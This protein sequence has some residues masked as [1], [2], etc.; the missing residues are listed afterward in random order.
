MRKQITRFESSRLQVAARGRWCV[1]A[2][3]VIALMA[4]TPAHAQPNPSEPDVQG[5]V[6][7]EDRSVGNSADLIVTLHAEHAATSGEA[8]AVSLDIHAKRDNDALFVEWGLPDGGALDGPARDTETVIVAGA[9]TASQR[10][11]T[12]ATPGVYR[13]VASAGDAS[14][15]MTRAVAVLFFHVDTGGRSRVTQRDEVARAEL[16]AAPNT[17]I[18]VDAPQAA[19]HD[20]VRRAASDPCFTVSGRVTRL[21]RPQTISGTGFGPDMTVPVRFAEVEIRESDLVFD[22]SYGAVITDADGRYSKVFCDDDG[23]FD[24]T[25]EIYVRLHASL[26]RNGHEVVN[27]SEHNDVLGIDLTAVTSGYEFDSGERSSEGGALTVNFQ[28]ESNRSQSAVFNIADAIYEGWQFWSASG[29]AQLNSTVD[30]LWEVGEGQTGSNYRGDFSTGRDIVIADSA[31]D[32]D[33]WDDSVIL[34]ELGHMLDDYFSCDDSPGG[35]HSMDRIAD[36][37]GDLYDLE[38]VWSEGYPNYFQS[39]VRQARRDPFASSYIDNGATGAT[40]RSLESYDT[41]TGPKSIR[42]ELAIAAMLWDLNDGSADYPGGADDDKI[43]LGHRAIQRVYTDPAFAANGDVFDDDCTVPVF[44]KVWKD[45]GLQA[46]AAAADAARRNL[47]TAAPFASSLAFAARTDGETA[48]TTTEA[49]L[50]D[51][52]GQPQFKWWKRHSVVI[53]TSTSMA[54]AKL[55]AAKAVVVEQVNDLTRNPAGTEMSV[56]RYDNTSNRVQPVVEGRFF[57]EQILPAVNALGPNGAPDP[58]CPSAGLEALGQAAR[59]QH[60]GQAWLITDGDDSLSINVESLRQ[61]L[62]EQRMRASVVL[63]A[64]CGTAATRQASLSGTEQEFLGLAADGSRPGGVVPYLLTALGSGGQFLFVRQD[65]LADAVKILR[66]GLNNSAGAGRWSDYVSDSYTL[67][68][69]QLTA[70]EYRWIDT[71]TAAGGT[72][73][74][75]AANGQINFD[76]SDGSR[77]TIFE[78]GYVRTTYPPA[79]SVFVDYNILRSNLPWF[80][81]TGGETGL[82]VPCENADCFYATRRTVGDWTAI[83]IAGIGGYGNVNLRSTGVTREF[84]YLINNVT[85][86]G[87]YQ[88]RSLIA[89]DSGA[90]VIGVGGN[91]HTNI[92]FSDRDVNGARDGMGY[93]NYNAPPQPTKSYTVAVDSL[94]SAVGFLQTGYSGTFERMIVRYPDGSEVSCSDTANVLCVSLNNGLVQYVQVDTN[95]RGGVYTAIVDAGSSGNGTFS[96]S[97]LAASAISAESADARIRPMT[98]ARLTVRLGSVA[99]GNALTGWLQA[100]NGARMG[101]GMTLHDDGEHGD[102]T[103]GDG[104][105]GSDP[106]APTT[107]GVGYLW[108]NGKIGNIAFTRSDPV[109]YTFQPVRV[110]SPNVLQTSGGSTYLGFQIHNQDAINRCFVLSVAL[111]SGWALANL[112]S[113]AIPGVTPLCLA[114]NNS[115]TFNVR[116]IT[117]AAFDTG[118]SGAAGDV[119]LTVTELEAGRIRAVSTTQIA[120]ARPV[121]YVVINNPVEDGY[122]PLGDSRPITLTAFFR[123]EQGALPDAGIAFFWS[124]SGGTLSAQPGNGSYPTTGQMQIG[125][126]PPTAAGVYTVAIQ[127]RLSGAT[128]EYT[129]TTIHVRAPIAADITLDLSPERLGTVQTSTARATVRDP[130][131]VAVANAEVRL[132]LDSDGDA[133]NLNGAEV[134]TGTTNSAGQFS[135]TFTKA[136][137][138]GLSAAIRAELLAR[139]GADYVIVD[140]DQRTVN[141]AARSLYLPVTSR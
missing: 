35:E 52:P 93:K 57:P 139:N 137:T 55:D 138:A 119:I 120:R 71:S 130:Y 141:M 8:V 128:Q 68:Y 83:T 60:D 85:G 61:R 124:T 11:V 2:A 133:G 1:I 116:V 22:D 41:T 16:A 73:L 94:I 115:G 129:S 30:V 50:P 42:N 108:V 127:T 114:A 43:A 122:V 12:F 64:G 58:S 34:H 106:F 96:F 36:K 118:P 9:A 78:N 15:D 51:Y 53:D 103:A 65:Q 47:G 76:N 45:L 86:E 40:S 74:P 4:L 125:Y 113:D 62:T 29:G 17:S 49:S 26:W 102:G 59:R 110:V 44:L 123:D 95:N 37:F 19:G 134:V 90:S 117:G 46:D 21:E 48:L 32:P 109:P 70:S 126:T 13:V 99:D 82:W 135:A 3:A 79:H 105:F 10:R 38:L 56:F 89:G 98:P 132:G 7:L 20:S 88:Y 80:V 87:R 104:D 14:D 84:Q 6:L 92:T 140:S 112:P 75:T 5:R 77:V 63:M 131:G 24:D 72:V 81:Y 27:V 67:R 101:S 91:F 69:D 107:A 25:L 100:P 28:L 111:P 66:A 54:G 39:A 97:A 23:V 136:Q 31:G 18:T 33:E 121:R